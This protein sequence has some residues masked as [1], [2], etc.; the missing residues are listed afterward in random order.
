MVTLYSMTPIE[1][2][3]TDSE[4]PHMINSMNMSRVDVPVVKYIN[5]Y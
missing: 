5:L 1:T 2:G 3:R 4:E